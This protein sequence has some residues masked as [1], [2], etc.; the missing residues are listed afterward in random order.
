MTLALEHILDV[1]K[2]IEVVNKAV[3]SVAPH[4]PVL[5]YA[6]FLIVGQ[7]KEDV[8]QVH[9]VL[10]PRIESRAHTVLMTV[11]ELESNARTLRWSTRCAV[12]L[13]NNT[14]LG[15]MSVIELESSLVYTR[16]CCIDDGWAI[17]EDDLLINMQGGRFYKRGRS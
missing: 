15:T 5:G 11:K 16:R 6:E 12:L 7:Y 13:L 3:G 1:D 2:V 14:R 17:T 9:D 10:R 4:I 8:Q